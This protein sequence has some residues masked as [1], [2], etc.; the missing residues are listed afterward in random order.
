M[1]DKKTRI[2]VVTGGSNGIGN[3]IAEKFAGE[4]I[5]VVIADI[6]PPAKPLKNSVFQFCDVTS[7]NAVDTLY[8]WVNTNIGNPDILVLNA[9]KGIHELLTEGDPEKWRQVIDLNITGVLRCIRAFVPLMLENKKGDV[10][11]ISSVSS[12]KPYQY[13]AV[14]AATKAAMDCIAETLRLETAPHIRTTVVNAG[15][16][17]TAFFSA[18]NQ[19]IK[20]DGQVLQATDIAA[21]V[22]YAVNKPAGTVVNTIVARPLGQ[23][24]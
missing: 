2:A 11:F 5:F 14:Y 19:E 6:I 22:W 13:G 8:K 4:A 17:D 12:S 16:T 23:I 15:I 1:E 21:D 24:F 18:A 20:K 7:G 9:G 3:A 10:V